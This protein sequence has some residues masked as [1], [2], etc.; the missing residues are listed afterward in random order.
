MVTF[1]PFW[2]VK[3]NMSS[4]YIIWVFTLSSPSRAQLYV[5]SKY[6]YTVFACLDLY[7]SGPPFQQSCRLAVKI[8]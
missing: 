2:F 6:M 4:I 1:R 7:L 3:I 5:R 8:P